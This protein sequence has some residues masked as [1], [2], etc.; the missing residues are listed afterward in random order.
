MNNAL[1]FFKACKTANLELQS[2]LAD[3]YRRVCESSTAK[4]MYAVYLRHN[5][6]G[7]QAGI[8]V[9]DNFMRIYINGKL[10]KSQSFE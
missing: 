9:V 8:I 6:N 4:S 7:S 2:M 3:G 5:R 1:P 10:V